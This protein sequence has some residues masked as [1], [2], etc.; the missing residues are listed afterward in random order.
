VLPK[1]PA[2][3]KPTLPTHAAMKPVAAETK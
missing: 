3:P 2:M 1:L